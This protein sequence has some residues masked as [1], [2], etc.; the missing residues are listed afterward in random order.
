M[1]EKCKEVILSGARNLKIA[2]LGVSKENAT[3]LGFTDGN[4]TLTAAAEFADIRVD[5]R[6]GII[7]RIMT[8][9]G[10]NVAFP[11]KCITLEKLAIG[12]GVEFDAD[13]WASAPVEKYY[14]IWF[15]TDA[16]VNEN[17]IK[18]VRHFYL[19][20]VSLGGTAE[21]A[22]SRTETQ[23]DNLE[24]SIVNCNDTN[25]FQVTEDYGDESE[26]G[27]SESGI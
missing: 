9:L 27:E 13:G 17:G 1:T 3:D 12:L 14:Q 11:L 8:A 7:R 2:P 5:Q 20:K 25:F 21:L 26:S 4:V 6:L 24:G 10:W 16:P 18:G 22:F 19:P 15:D 23:T